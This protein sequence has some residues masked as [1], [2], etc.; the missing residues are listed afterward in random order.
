MCQKPEYKFSMKLTAHEYNFKSLIIEIEHLYD[1][2]WEIFVFLS[3][4][5][6]IT[7]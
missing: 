5:K 3:L 2:I 1:V 6:K 7:Q 4:K